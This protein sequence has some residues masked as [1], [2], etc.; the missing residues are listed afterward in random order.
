MPPRGLNQAALAAL[1]LVGLGGLACGNGRP[2]A[3]LASAAVSRCT[4][5]HGGGDNQTGAPPFDVSGRSDPTLPSVGAHTAH[6]QSG[7]A[8]VAPAF[9]CD[10]CHVKPATVDAPGHR[11][12]T[13]QITF[14]ALATANGTLSPAYDT[15]T[16][17]CATVYCHGAFPAGNAANVPVWTAGPSQAACG[18]CHGDPAAVPSALPGAHARL[19]SGS[20]NATCNVCHPETVL[21]DGT[22]DVAGGK[23][24]DGL[25]EVDPEAMHPAGWLDPSS[26]QFHGVAAAPSVDPCLRCHAPDLPAKVTTIVCNGCHG[27]I[28]SPIV[29]TP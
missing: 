9:D 27:L 3:G 15:R 6:V 12:G 16:S 10:A 17:G 22:V 5:C 26:A 18:T 20:T 25:P 11:D 2:V 1:T 24:V 21:A 7:P 8:S 19:A 29:P 28:G 23:H 4:E 13:V 14:G